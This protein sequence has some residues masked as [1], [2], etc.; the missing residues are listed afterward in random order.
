MAEGLFWKRLEILR[1]LTRHA[2]EGRGP[3]ILEIA[4]S[5]GLKS[6]QTVYHHLTRLEGDGYVEREKGRPRTTRLTGKGWEAVGHTP[7]LGRVAAGRGIEAIAIQDGASLAAALLVSSSGRPRYVLAATGDSMMEARIEEGDMLLVE[8]NTDPPDGKV[9]VALLHNEKVTVKRL[10]REGEM[11]RLEPQN[12]EHE[13]IVV[14]AE[15]VLVQGEVIQVI[16]PP[17]R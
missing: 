6:S 9:V 4:A 10:Q 13:D 7:F 5:V 1:F 2:G 17:K 16:H 15:E 3:T 11:V 8:E 12:A 14:P